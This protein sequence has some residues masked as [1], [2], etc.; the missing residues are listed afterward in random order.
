[1]S[2][3]LETTQ[4]DLTHQVSDVQRISRGVKSHVDP[5]GRIIQTCGE[6]VSIRRVVDQS[7]GLEI[8][9]QTSSGHRPMLPRGEVRIA[10]YSWPIPAVDHSP[11]PPLSD[12]ETLR[13]LRVQS[14]A[15]AQLGS[16]MYAG[17]F[18]ALADDY[19]SG[20]PTHA[21]LYGRSETP[22]H[23]A[24]PLRLA[25]AMH[26]VV[27]GGEDPRLARHYPSVGGTPG[28]TFVTDFISSLQ[29]HTI[30]IEAGLASQVQTNEVGRSLVPLMLSHWLRG[31]GI[32]E[33]DHWEVGASAG[34]N[35]CFD[36]YRA[37]S[38]SVQLGDPGS[39]VVFG[40][41]WF[42]TVP[43]VP[44]APARV[45]ERRGVDPY[46]VD[47]SDSKQQL[48][49]LSFVWPD[50]PER[51]MRLRAA[52]DLVTSFPPRIDTDS[53]DSWLATQ[54]STQRERATVVFHSIVWQ[55]LGK[56]VQ[57]NVRHV[58]ATYGEMATAHSPLLWV[59]MEPAGPIAD[60]RATIWNGSEQPDEIVLAEIGY[61]GRN[62]RWL[63]N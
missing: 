49:L 61:H 14:V 55:Y 8:G 11:E 4:S 48:R 56:T 29:D 60:V 45:V 35:M 17:L 54:L 21:L 39:P 44:V 59:R 38:G 9:K 40:P 6:C 5:D 42:D 62:L 3:H 12:D 34:L 53:A 1:M 28:A 22:I 16:S 51:L 41:D 24:I 50:Q 43:D 7:P 23:D 20:G 2:R 36:R 57:D 47:I 10:T 37:D 25:G 33:F 63:G 52:I 13:S 27:L 18:S 58:L 32:D 15:C 26:R 31:R 46:P 19:E 30:E